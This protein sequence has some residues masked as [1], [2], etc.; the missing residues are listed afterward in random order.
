MFIGEY[1]HSLDSKGR[2]AIPYKFRALLKK[3][4]IIAKGLDGCLFLY[5]KV[6][7]Q[8]MAQELAK[9]TFNRANNRAITRH[10]LAS[11]IDLKFDVQG[12][13]TLPDY[14]RQFANLKKKV[15]IAGLYDRLEIWDE[16]AWNKYKTETEKQT[17]TIA[18]TLDHLNNQ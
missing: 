12:R 15:I 11:A 7:W 2:L 10:F 3:G 6:A 16:T 1:Q 13:V 8:T 9:R 14:L 17:E 18:E 4:C 5:T